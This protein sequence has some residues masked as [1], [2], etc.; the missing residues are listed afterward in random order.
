VLDPKYAPYVEIN[1]TEMVAPNFNWNLTAVESDILK[2][3]VDVY[4]TRLTSNSSKRRL[5][6]RISQKMT[7][8]SRRT[9]NKIRKRRR[10]KRN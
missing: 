4:N 9:T 5:L 1:Y 7:L 6:V 8:S 10:N 3:Y 2:S